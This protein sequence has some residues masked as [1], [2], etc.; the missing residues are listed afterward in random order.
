MEE[1]RLYEEAIANDQ[2]VSLFYTK[3]LALGPGQVGKTTFLYRLMGL[4]KGN[5]KTADPKTLPQSSTGIAEQQE[6]CITYTSTTGTLTQ[7]G[8]WQ[9][10]DKSSDLQC[11]LNGLMSLLIEQTSPD[12]PQPITSKMKRAF[13]IP[14]N[15]LKNLIPKLQREKSIENDDSEI[16][17]LESFSEQD[18]D[19]KEV[20]E[21]SDSEPVISHPQPQESNIG[22]VMLE[23]ENIRTLC[24]LTPNKTKFKM[25]FNI[26][27]IGGQPAFLE[28]LPSLTIGPALYLIF[29]KLLQGLKTRYPTA[30]KCKSGGS[31][32]CK[33]YTYTSEEVIFTALSSIACFGN[34]D[35]EIERYVTSSSD[36]KE[37][38]S[39]ALL[40]GTFRDEIKDEKL[41]DSI[42]NQLKVQLEMTDFFNR[43]LIYSNTFLR[44]NNYSAKKTEIE[45]QRKLLE[46]I[47][48]RKFHRY[49]I[50]TRW[51]TLSICL[52]LLSRIE[53]RHDVSFVDCVD[54][55]SRLGMEEDMVK[56]ALQFL[57][58]YIG[59][60]MYFQKMNI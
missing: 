45:D 50:P 60:V 43:G 17:L 13:N 2:K 32:L 39:L 30:F 35:E 53:G 27:D 36:S 59:L 18:S 25:L 46:E 24:K 57:H 6:V 58:K 10:F 28:M 4:M 16:P 7:S 41:L 31:K 11:M 21:E 48:K 1:V 29:M 42:D 55:G 8:C 9:I 22:Q 49:E 56:V 51:L 54:L 3:I 44:V 34:S 14:V 19:H 12:C 40:V 47:L 20:L 5:I 26:A 38:N 15:K 37:T 52:K 23:F 33:N